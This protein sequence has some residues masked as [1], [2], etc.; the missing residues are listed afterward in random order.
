[1]LYNL[2]I[3]S[4]D[5]H[6]LFVGAQTDYTLVRSTFGGSDLLVFYRDLIRKAA[7]DLEEIGLAVLQNQAPRMRVN[8]KAELRAIEYEIELMRKQELPTQNPEAYSAVSS[9]FRRIWSATR[10]IDKM[11]RS[12]ASEPSPTETELRID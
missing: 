10:L 6:E 7:E 8:V 9:N 12:L 5:L 1:M 11:R 2:F 4:V 3:N